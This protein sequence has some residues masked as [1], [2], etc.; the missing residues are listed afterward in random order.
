MRL[1]AQRLIN[2]IRQGS[3]QIKAVQIK[4]VTILEQFKAFVSYFMNFSFQ[5]LCIIFE[6]LHQA[7][8]CVAPPYSYHH[9]HR[10]CHRH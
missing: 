4:M 6:K 5:A 1:F 3:R 10:H 2:P 8:L 7:V 9:H